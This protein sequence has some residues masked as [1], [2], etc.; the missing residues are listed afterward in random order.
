[1][2]HTKMARPLICSIFIMVNAYCTL[3]RYLSTIGAGLYFSVHVFLR[4][5]I[6][7]LQGLPS[8]GAFQKLSLIKNDFRGRSCLGI[9][10]LSSRISLAIYIRA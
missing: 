4:S 1:M 5:F 2:P 7:F 9:L 6:F 3:A 8:S 10:N